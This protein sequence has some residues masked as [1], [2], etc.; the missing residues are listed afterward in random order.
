MIPDLGGLPRPYEGRQS[1][2]N[3][4]GDD[5]QPASVLPHRNPACV[6]LQ[7]LIENEQRGL[8]VAME[9]LNVDDVV[10]GVSLDNSR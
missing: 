10:H 2:F 9:E 4:Q 6:S 7:R 3:I 8:V 1:F 5:V